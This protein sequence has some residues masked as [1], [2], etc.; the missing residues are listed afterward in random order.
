MT[1]EQAEAQARQCWP[2]WVAE[3]T[4]RTGDYVVR[5]AKS[6]EPGLLKA[7]ARPGHASRAEEHDGLS[8]ESFF[9]ALQDLAKQIPPDVPLPASE[10]DDPA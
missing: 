9:G 5:I 2:G 1:K 7:Q 4:I 8:S 6:P 3:A 10:P